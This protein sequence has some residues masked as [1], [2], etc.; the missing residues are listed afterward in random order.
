MKTKAQSERPVSGRAKGESGFML[1]YAVAMVAIVMIATAV[2]VPVIAKQLRRDKEVES[3][4]RMEQY[5]RAIQLYQRAC[6]CTNYPPSMEALETGTNV[7]FLRQ[8]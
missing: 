3:M 1:V 8:E 2:A 7:R 5:V 4:H 6:K